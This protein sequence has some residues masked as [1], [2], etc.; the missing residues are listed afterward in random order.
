MRLQRC[1]TKFD[2]KSLDYG[3]EKCGVKKTVL[4]RQENEMQRK[5]V[6]Y[7]IKCQMMTSRHHTLRIVSVLLLLLLWRC[8]CESDKEQDAS[9]PRDQEQI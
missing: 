8:H 1:Q 3:Q 2:S 6:L 5:R 7:Y 9:S 4:L